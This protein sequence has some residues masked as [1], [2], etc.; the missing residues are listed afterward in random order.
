MLSNANARSDF[1]MYF[2]RYFENIFRAACFHSS[3]WNTERKHKGALFHKT[4]MVIYLCAFFTV[5]QLFSSSDI[6]F[7][8]L[9]STAKAER[10]VWILNIKGIT[11]CFFQLPFKS[12]R[13]TGRLSFRGE[14]RGGGIG[15]DNILWKYL[16]EVLFCSVY[17][18]LIKANTI[19]FCCAIFIWSDRKGKKY[20]GSI[21]C[22]RKIY[23][24]PVF[25]SVSSPHTRKRCATSTKEIPKSISRTISLRF[26]E[27]KEKRT[28][29]SLKRIQPFH[30][31]R[32]FFML[33]YISSRE[34]IYYFTLSL[35]PSPPLSD[36]RKSTRW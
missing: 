23:N 24:V 8:E 22:E 2:Q 19:W 26:T 35:D 29:R 12:S 17:R 33:R 18:L 3:D 5:H 16:I 13:Y 11:P 21:G 9:K 1:S 10:M 4:W 27:K 34:M 31:F 14:E 25:F 32:P 30:E 28:T 20:P 7:M 6:K 15:E 36:W